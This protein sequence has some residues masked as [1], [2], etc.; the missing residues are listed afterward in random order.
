MNQVARR[1]AGEVRR[2][3]AAAERLRA[4]QASGEGDLREPM[5]AERELVRSLVGAAREL[6]AVS[7]RPASEPTLAAVER[8]LHAAAAD[9]AVHPDL[10]AGALTREIEA[11]GF[12]GLLGVT[13]EGGPRRAR[14]RAG[15]EERSAARAA[16]R[17][18]RAEARQAREEAAAAE[19]EVMR[20]RDE[21]RRAEREAE[22]ARERAEEAQREVERSG[23]G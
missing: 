23:P 12:A 17:R 16:L 21:L 9:P 22:R 4:A 1:N 20:L 19:R 10:E 6:L 8:T 14:A 18:A 3:L 15:A 13:L 5:L 7:G 11:S 2:L